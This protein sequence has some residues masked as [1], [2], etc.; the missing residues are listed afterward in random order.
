MDLLGKAAEQQR[1][2]QQHQ[3]QLISFRSTCAMSNLQALLAQPKE[4]GDSQERDIDLAVVMAEK[5]MLRL[6]LIP[7][8]KFFKT[9]EEMKAEKEGTIN[10]AESH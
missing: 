5:L 3:M 10:N 1:A 4:Y 7:D 9:P 2:M 6:G 8:A